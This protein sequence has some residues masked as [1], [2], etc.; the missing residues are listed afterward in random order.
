M[1]FYPAEPPSG[2]DDPPLG[3][4]RPGS[5]DRKN[6]AVNSLVNGRV[7]GIALLAAYRWLALSPVDLLRRCRQARFQ[8]SGPGGQ[9]RNRVYSGVRVT[10]TDSGISAESVDSRASL[11]NLE[12]AVARL[13]LSLAL[14]AAYLE[15]HPDECLAEVPQSVFRVGASASHEDYPRFLLRALHWL[16]WHKG[17]VAA[18]AAALDC[19]ASALTRFFKTDKAAWARTRG[20]RADNG[21]HPLK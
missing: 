10:H 6:E 3:D 4:A 1:H 12:A 2:G 19:T 16:A 18:A 13:R 17:Q 5:S 21:L 15:R 7:E 20:I 11:R 8:G 9:K 14:S